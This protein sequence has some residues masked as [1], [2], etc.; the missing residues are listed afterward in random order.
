ME[1]TNYKFYFHNFKQKFSK[2]KFNKLAIYANCN[3]NGINVRF[4]VS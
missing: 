4:Y 2:K 3:M 1:K